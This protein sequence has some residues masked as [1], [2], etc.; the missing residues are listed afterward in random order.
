MQRTIDTITP[1]TQPGGIFQART[2]G[3]NRTIR[4][5]DDR[6][7]RLELRVQAYEERLG[8]QFTAMELVVSRL[9]EQGNYLASTL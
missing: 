7:A 3:I 4:Q 9:K 5:I 2:E 1:Y 6:I 8:E